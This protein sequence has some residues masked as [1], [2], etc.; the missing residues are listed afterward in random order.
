MNK[1]IILSDLVDALEMQSSEITYYFNKKEQT[2]V[3]V[4]DDAYCDEEENRKLLKDIE[5]NFNNYLA[6]PTEYEINEYAI[7]EAFVDEQQVEVKNILTSILN[8]KRPFRKFQ[9]KVFELDI[10]DEWFEFRKDRLEKIA[11]DWCENN[12]IFCH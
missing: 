10:R 8:A 4:M 1:D 6:L 11:V 12:S 9:D 5:N 3:F 2:L 7:M